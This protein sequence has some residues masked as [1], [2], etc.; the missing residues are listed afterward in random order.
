M[1]ERKGEALSIEYF[2]QHIA[3][4]A[5][6]SF[7]GK[8]RTQ[9]RFLPKT[10]FVNGKTIQRNVKICSSIFQVNI[11]THVVTCDHMIMTKMSKRSSTAYIYC[12]K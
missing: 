6:N 4:R 3:S 12:H 2:L 11:T 9:A 10:G 5:F 7:N 8:L 1:Y